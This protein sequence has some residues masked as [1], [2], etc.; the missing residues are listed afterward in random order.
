MV[1]EQIVQQLRQIIEKP[2]YIY[3]MDTHNRA[4]RSE[5]VILAVNSEDLIVITTP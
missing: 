4:A 2:R 5:A 3:E 1:K